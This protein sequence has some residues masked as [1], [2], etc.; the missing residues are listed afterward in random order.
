MSRIYLKT[1]SNLTSKFSSLACQG[2]GFQLLATKYKSNSLSKDSESAIKNLEGT[3]DLYNTLREAY[4]LRLKLKDEEAKNL[5]Q[6]IIDEYSHRHNDRLSPDENY[7]LAWANCE[8]GSMAGDLNLTRMVIPAE[9]STTYYKEAIKVLENSSDGPKKEIDYL[10]AEC[11]NKLGLYYRWVDYKY[12]DSV[13]YF[14]KALDIYE[15]YYNPIGQA[16]MH[17]NMYMS[18]ILI[19]DYDNCYDELSVFLKIALTAMGEEHAMLHSNLEQ[20]VRVEGIDYKG[21]LEGIEGKESMLNN[22]ELAKCNDLLGLMYA[23]RGSYSKSLECL[24]KGFELKKELLAKEDFQNFEGFKAVI[25]DLN[26]IGKALYLKEFFETLFKLPKEPQNIPCL[27]EFYGGAANIHISLSKPGY[28]KPEEAL[29]FAYEG[30]GLLEKNR[31]LRQVSTPICFIS[32]Y[33]KEILKRV[34]GLRLKS[35][36]LLH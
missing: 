3:G 10:I 28:D 27:F 32:Y 13:K 24:V 4:D 11:N 26:W 31:G 30:L 14:Q 18:Q 19:K 6:S 15:N 23:Y 2:T 34:I 33:I 25:T 17:L 20:D 1:L 35:M 16:E 36:L 9:V 21:I 5:Y 12:D 22:M 7:V 29:K 8:L